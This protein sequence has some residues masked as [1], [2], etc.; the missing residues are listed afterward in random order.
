MIQ[1]PRARCVDIDE[2]KYTRRLATS[3][4]HEFQGEYG[5]EA[6]ERAT[7][8]REVRRVLNKPDE[9]LFRKS[10][11]RGLKWKQNFRIVTKSSYHWLLTSSSWKTSSRGTEVTGSN[12]VEALIFSGFSFPVAWIGKFTTMIILHVHQQPQFK[13]ELFHILHIKPKIV[14]MLSFTAWFQ[15]LY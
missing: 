15:D 7:K 10:S 13:Y 8:S 2:I 9:G 11:T 4:P 6:A 3:R 5:R 12:P 14:L 1:G